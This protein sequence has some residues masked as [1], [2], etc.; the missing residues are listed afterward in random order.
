MLLIY[1]EG[2]GYLTLTDYFGF[3]AHWVPEEE[4][5]K[6]FT[7]EEVN[8]IMKHSAWAESIKKKFEIIEK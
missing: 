4:Q 3:P 2:W 6:R 7:E 5:A 1:K 8:Y